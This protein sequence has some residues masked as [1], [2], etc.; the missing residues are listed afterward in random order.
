MFESCNNASKDSTS[1]NLLASANVFISG[2]IVRVAPATNRMKSLP[3]TDST[4]VLPH[5]PKPTMAALII[6]YSTLLC[7]NN[8]KSDESCTSNPEIRNRKLDRFNFRFLISGFEVQDSSDFT[9]PSFGHPL[10]CFGTYT[11]ML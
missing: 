5:Q 2:E 7:G 4:R 10:R 3:W 6:Y 8:L 11:L 9:M 1:L